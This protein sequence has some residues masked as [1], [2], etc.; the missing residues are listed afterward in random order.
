MSNHSSH[1]KESGKTLAPEYG[2]ETVT[3]A[4]SRLHRY[5]LSLGPGDRAAFAAVLI[6]DLVTF[7]AMQRMERNAR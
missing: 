5:Y 1:I 4:E 2:P 3:E 6:K 7:K